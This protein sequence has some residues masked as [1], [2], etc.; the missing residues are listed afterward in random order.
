MIQKGLGMGCKANVGNSIFLQHLKLRK[1]T[2]NEQQIS[3]KTSNINMENEEFCRETMT[4]KDFQMWSEL[5]LK[6]YLSL[7][8]KNVDGDFE[9]LV[10]R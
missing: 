7:R 2:I 10:Y 1:R 5:S 4:L 6:N 3:I 9:T 8:K